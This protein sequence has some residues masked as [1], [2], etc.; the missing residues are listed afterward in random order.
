MRLVAIGHDEGA[1][2]VRFEGQVMAGASVSRTVTVKEQ[3]AE[4]ALESLTEHT[5]VVVPF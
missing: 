5:T 3:F 2:R 4:F 1:T